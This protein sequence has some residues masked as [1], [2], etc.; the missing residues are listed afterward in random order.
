M[1]RKSQ[2]FAVLLAMLLSS[3][4][5][6]F[7]ADPKTALATAAQNQFGLR[8][9][10]TLAAETPH[11][12]IFLS[13][14][15][16]FLALSTLDL[17]AAGATHAAIREAL[18]VPAG[19]TDSDFHSSASALAQS[20]Q[21]RPG[22]DLSFATALWSDH[23]VEF[24]PDFLA[25]SLA[26]YQAHAASLD[27]HSP[28]AADTINRWVSDRTAG[29]IPDIVSARAVA[30]SKAI[31]TN[32]VYFKGKWQ[33]AFNPKLTQ[34]GD[35][36]LTGGNAKVVPFMRQSGMCN[37]W[38]GADAFE[39][40]VL[41]YEGDPDDSLALCVLLP[42]AGHD[43][44]A[45]LGNIDLH[46][47]LTPQDDVPLDLTLPRFTLDYAASLKAALIH[48]GM[49]LAFEY[50]AADFSPLGSREFFVGDVLHKTRLEV[51]EA[52]SV[53]AAATAI[54]APMGRP[55]QP[56]QQKIMVVNRPFAVLL[57][58]RRTEAILFA[59]IV[60]EP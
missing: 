60:Y 11:V 14:S 2:I 57:C 48:L 45:T 53:A 44:A 52:G 16:V 18:N 58:D 15:S 3:L 38:R 29:K 36:F 47:L 26:L 17:G 34:P 50:P 43:V 31:L 19:V 23:A 41:S 37:A 4:G 6:T 42:A 9:L 7:G 32:A 25:R 54:L 1:S 5:N 51:D 21:P 55:H 56:I 8:L 22:I 35:F 59:G 24:A 28:S 46:R 20:L 27:F 13:P 40:A 30:A 12:N 49:T 39:A 33:N 10:T